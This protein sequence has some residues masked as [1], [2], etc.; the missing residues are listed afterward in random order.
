MHDLGID[1]LVPLQCQTM[2]DWTRVMGG[3]DLEARARHT[4]SSKYL[5]HTLILKQEI[6]AAAT[7]MFHNSTTPSRGEPT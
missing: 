7:L 5:P 4:P 6:L 1:T 3:V 2:S